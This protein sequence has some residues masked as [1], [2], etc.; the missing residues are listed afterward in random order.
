MKLQSNPQEPFQI[1][2]LLKDTSAGGSRWAAG[3][4]SVLIFSLPSAQI[5][6]QN[7]KHIFLDFHT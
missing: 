6:R 7:G 3:H 2:G 1:S 4:P 5:M